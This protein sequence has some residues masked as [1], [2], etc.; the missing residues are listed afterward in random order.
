MVR[1][2]NEWPEAHAVLAAKRWNEGA[3]ATE[4]SKD[5]R[6]IGG[7]YSRNSVIGKIRRLG[8]DKRSE[9]AMAAAHQNNGRRKPPKVA[10]TPRC[11]PSKPKARPT[12]VA[13]AAPLPPAVP[14]R[15]GDPIAE[16]AAITSLVTPRD[17]TL[18]IDLKACQCRWPIRDAPMGHAENTL[19]CARATVDGSPYCKDHHTTAYGKATPEQR[20]AAAKRWTAV[21]KMVVRFSR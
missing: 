21:K 19:F 10:G 11:A 16:I 5:L 7:V 1:S 3:S 18:L 6:K 8:L 17:G 12:P 2:V 15:R 14:V 13:P 20:A 4:I 9:S